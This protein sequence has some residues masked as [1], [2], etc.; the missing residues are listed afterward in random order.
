MGYSWLRGFETRKPSL[1]LH[2]RPNVRI[3]LRGGRYVAVSCVLNSSVN[4]WRIVGSLAMKR[5]GI[6]STVCF[7]AA[8]NQPS[9]MA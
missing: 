4:E 5:R 1:I 8:Q 6:R 9:R 2:P 7:R 3:D